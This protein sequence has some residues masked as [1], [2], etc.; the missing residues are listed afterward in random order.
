MPMLSRRRATNCRELGLEFFLPLL[1]GLQPKLPAMKLDTELVDIT[2]DFSA[3]RFILFELMLQVGSLGQIRI[4]DRSRF[5]AL[6][7]IQRHPGRGRIDH[8]RRGAMRASENNI[9][10]RFLS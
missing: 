8:E 1:Q 2:C 9:A 7:A 6:L 5:A 10:A 3:L 4:W